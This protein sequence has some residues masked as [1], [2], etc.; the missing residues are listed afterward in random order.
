MVE[1]DHWVLAIF[2][3]ASLRKL[4]IHCFR[5]FSVRARVKTHLAGEHFRCLTFRSL[6]RF[7]QR[8]N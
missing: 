7:N 3:T 8:V 1:N 2:K 5:E 6:N 4:E